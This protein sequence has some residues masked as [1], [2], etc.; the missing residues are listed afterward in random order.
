MTEEIIE[1]EEVLIEEDQAV[2][3]EDIAVQGGWKP[4]DDW[5]GSEGEWIDART[6]NMRG[7]LMDRIKSQTSQLRGQERKITRLEGSMEQLA[8]HNRKMDEVAYKKALNELKGLKRDAL[9]MADH[10]QVMEIDDRI[11]DLKTIQK[12][13]D[14]APQQEGQEV[15]PEVAEWIESNSWYKDDV[16]LRGAADALTMEMVQAFPELRGNPSAVL[17]KVAKRL[18]DEFPAKFGIKKRSAPK[19]VAEPGQADTTARSRGTVKKFTAKHLNEVQ[20]KF[21][22]DFVRDGVMKDLNEYASQLAELGDLDV[23]RGA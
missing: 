10:D 23:Q 5:E 8:D 9:D 22:R 7:E 6:F 14:T 20:M 13:A 16:T 19:G 4:E 15:N 1:K 2:T 11:D 21:G 12:G 17:D 3:A 18:K